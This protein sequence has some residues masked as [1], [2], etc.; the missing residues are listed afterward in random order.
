MAVEAM[1]ELTELQKKHTELN[2]GLKGFQRRR[3]CDGSKK[4]KDD[5]RSNSSITQDSDRKD[6]IR[7]IKFAVR[8]N[9]FQL[10]LFR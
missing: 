4:P 5:N 1:S 10:D 9:I 6:D 2:S 3:R 7:H 8:V